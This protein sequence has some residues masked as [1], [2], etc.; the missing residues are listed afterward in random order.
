[1]KPSKRKSGE[2]IDGIAALA[3]ALFCA[4]IPLEAEVEAGFVPLAGDHY[5]DELAD[6]ND[7]DALEAFQ[8]EYGVSPAEVGALAAA[9][10]ARF[11]PDDDD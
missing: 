7:V 1:M 11:F 2:K 3:T 6:L 9:Q 10:V 5:A 8:R 4:A